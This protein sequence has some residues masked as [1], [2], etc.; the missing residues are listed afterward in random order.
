MIS[1]IGM[2]GTKEN[3]N[4]GANL[5]NDIFRKIDEIEGNEG[6]TLPSEVFNGINRAVHGASV[7]PITIIEAMNSR[8]REGENLP[9]EELLFQ[10]THR[11]KEVRA[12]AIAKYLMEAQDM[13]ERFNRNYHS[14]EEAEEFKKMIA[15]RIA[16]LLT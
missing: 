16:V 10:L 8:V 1:D 5:P 12:N 4:N 15:K 7:E 6:R 3:R 2:V 13:T 9:F 11:S 14:K